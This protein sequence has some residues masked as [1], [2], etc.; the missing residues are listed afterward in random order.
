MSFFYAIRNGYKPGIYKDWTS[1]KRQVDGFPGAIYKKFKNLED[2]KYFFETGKNPEKS[3]IIKIRPDGSLSVQTKDK[4]KEKEIPSKSPP[5]REQKEKEKLKSKEPK[6]TKEPKVFEVWTDGSCLGNGKKEPK[7]GIGIYFGEDDHRN[8]SKVLS[9]TGCEVPS[10]QKAELKAIIVSMD[11]LLKTPDPE[12]KVVIYT[13]SAYSINVVVKWAHKWKENG[14]KTVSGEPVKNQELIKKL[15]NN[16]SK[17][18]NNFKS[19][20]LKHIKAH[21]SAPLNKNS[22]AYKLWYGNEQ[23]DKLAK[24]AAL[25]E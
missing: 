13:D 22:V 7:G 6:E 1:A 25:K 24:K 23:A 20:E 5:K 16:H 4:K 12:K 14:F 2:A 11:I 8:T 18:Q 17:M 3:G 19:I 21:T 9:G 10:N 15:V